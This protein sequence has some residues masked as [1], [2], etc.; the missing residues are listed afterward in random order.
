MRNF[1]DVTD[2]NED[3]SDDLSLID[4]IGKNVRTL[5][6]KASISQYK[7]AAASGVSRDTIAKIESGRTRSITLDTMEKLA[8][9]LGADVDDL[10]HFE[11]RTEAA[12]AFV[13]EFLASDYARDL[14]IT[15][16]EREWL[17][18]LDEVT[19]MGRQPTPKAISLLVEALRNTKENP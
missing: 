10:L 1:V 2:A 4:Y 8:T 19:F 16:E 13:E 12:K 6:E 14:A 3:P 9:G 7:L 15:D 17:L 18:G 11:T 5:R